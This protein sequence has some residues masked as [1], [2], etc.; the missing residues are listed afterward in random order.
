MFYI[1]A[2]D[3]FDFPVLEAFLMVF[4]LFF[5]FPVSEVTILAANN[6]SMFNCL[7]RVVHGVLVTK[8]K[9]LKV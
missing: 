7:V 5:V 8:R 9:Q 2:S 3:I 6:N 1:Q 4:V